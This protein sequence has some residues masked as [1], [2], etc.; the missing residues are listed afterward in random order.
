MQREVDKVVNEL[1]DAQENLE[2]INSRRKINDKQPN[3]EPTNKQIAELNRK[4]RRAKNKKAKNKLIARKELLKMGPRQLNSA[5][6]NAYTSY[7]ID[8]VEIDLYMFLNRTK[9]T[10]IR[11]LNKETSR[12]SIRL[13]ITTWV[14]FIKDGVE[15]VKL[16]FNSRMVSVYKFSEMGEIVRSAMEDVLHQYENPALRNS[17][18][19]FDKVLRMDINFHRLNLTR[20]SS[21][22]ELPD[23]LAAKKAIINPRNSD[24]IMNVLNG[25]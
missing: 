24:Y 9:E 3:P 1:K 6:G 16:A 11:L 15:V 4:I 18:F 7:R 17:K 14:R 21:Y 8:G 19:V 20:G 13:Q 10:L 22:I 2:E 23:W 5:F 25:Q 12:E